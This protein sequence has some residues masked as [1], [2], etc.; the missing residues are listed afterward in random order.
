MK[1][2]E[3]QSFDDIMNFQIEHG[4]LSALEDF[5]SRMECKERLGV[6]PLWSEIWPAVEK[7][8]KAKGVW[9]VIP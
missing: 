7:L 1:D 6:K 8:A 5:K 3:K 9:K 2:P 4:A